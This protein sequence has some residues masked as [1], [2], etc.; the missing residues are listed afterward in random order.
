M[1]FPGRRVQRGSEGGRPRATAAHPAGAPPGP[2]G[3][4]PEGGDQFAVEERGSH[5]ATGPATHP[6]ELTGGSSNVAMDF[7]KR[8]LRLKCHQNSGPQVGKR[9]MNWSQLSVGLWG[10]NPLHSKVNACVWSPTW[11]I[12]S[13]DL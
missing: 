5:P 1:L 9:A 6:T 11:Q 3:G 4:G 10:G 8:T 13:Q 7:N 12:F 2:G